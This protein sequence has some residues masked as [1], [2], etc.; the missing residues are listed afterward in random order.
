MENACHELDIKGLLQG[1]DGGRGYEAYVRSFRRDV[2]LVGK[3]NTV[4]AAITLLQQL[5]TIL[6]ISTSSSAASNSTGYLVQLQS[7]IADK[8]RELQLMVNI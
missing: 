2:E 5:V 4:K 3:S 7:A 1:V 6:T 8:K